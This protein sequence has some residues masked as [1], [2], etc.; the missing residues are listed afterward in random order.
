MSVTMMDNESPFERAAR[1]LETVTGGP[2]T[3]VDVRTECEELRAENDLLR[4]GIANEAEAWA[5]VRRRVLYLLGALSDGYS[6][7]DD[8]EFPYVDDPFTPLLGFFNIRG[9]ELVDEYERQILVHA[10]DDSGQ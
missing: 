4:A 3:P 5:E 2:S 6:H 10:E 8:Y 1:S 9:Q 7:F